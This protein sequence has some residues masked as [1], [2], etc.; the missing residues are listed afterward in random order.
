MVKFLS[1]L[2]SNPCKNRCYNVIYRIKVKKKKK[3]TCIYLHLFG[4]I[5]ISKKLFFRT[6]CKNMN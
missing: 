6:I 4:V 2:A 5:C 3:K 1:L